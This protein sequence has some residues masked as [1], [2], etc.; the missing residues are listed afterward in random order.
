MLKPFF[1][2]GDAESLA[3]PVEARGTRGAPV[4]QLPTQADGFLKTLPAAQSLELGTEMHVSA[5]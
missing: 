2:S 4:P 1:S 5:I 3:R